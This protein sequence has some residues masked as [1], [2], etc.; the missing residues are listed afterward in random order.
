MYISLHMVEAI[1]PMA[2]M[3]ATLWNRLRQNPCVFVGL[4]CEMTVSREMIWQWISQKQLKILSR[5]NYLT[6]KA[7]YLSEN[8]LGLWCT[9]LRM[10]LGLSTTWTWARPLNKVIRLIGY[11]NLLP[12]ILAFSGSKRRMG[13]RAPI[14][15]TKNLMLKF[16]Y[17]LKYGYISPRR[18]WQ[19]SLFTV[20]FILWGCV[21]HQ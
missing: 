16:G 10:F 4:A 5:G 11:H 12:V 13:C 2:A 15:P 8:G 17:V 19:V 18:G 21:P 14:L 20:C 7:S 9:D 1:T 6:K 3:A